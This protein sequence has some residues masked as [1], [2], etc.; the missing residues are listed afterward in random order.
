MRSLRRFFAGA[1]FNVAAAYGLFGVVWIVV[2]DRLVAAFAETSMQAARVQTV[3]GWIFVGLSSIVVYGLVLSGQRD[4]QA[5][6]ERLNTA[7]QQINILHRILRHNLRNSCNVIQGNAELLSGEL[8]GEPEE[9]AETIA[10]QN[11]RL[12][13]LSEK[14]KRLRDVVFEDSPP[15]RHVDL[16]S[17]IDDR[18][19]ALREANPN[20]TV[21]ADLPDR[22]EVETDPR[23]G[24]ALDELLENALE[25]NDADRPTVRVEVRSAGSGK[26]VIDVAD[27]GPGIP[28]IERQVLEKGFEAPLFHSQGLGLWIART[29]V[30]HM[31]G[32]FRIVDNEP[33]GSVVRLT[34]PP[35]PER[36]RSRPRSCPRPPRTQKA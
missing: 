10:A 8:S 3:K 22:L 17:L 5:T 19:A 36:G 16:V 34:L 13:E 20:A 28:E 26:V 9:Y 6:N 18:L 15:R 27:D 1:P 14:S 12:V 30:V 11:E 24:D 31:G 4:L 21:E 29:L 33:R 7:L 25:H 35:A 2:T 32:T 23:I